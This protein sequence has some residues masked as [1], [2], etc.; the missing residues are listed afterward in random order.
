MKKFFVFMIIVLSFSIL[1]AELSDTIWTHP[2]WGI[3]KAVKFSPDGKYIYAGSDK[4]WIT[5]IDA[6]TNKEIYGINTPADF[7]SMDLSKDGKYILLTASKDTV[8]LINAEDKA[9]IRQFIIP[10]GTELKGLPQNASI[11][12]DSKYCSITYHRSLPNFKSKISILVWELETGKL[13]KDIDASNPGADFLK[14]SPRENIF[15]VGNYKGDNGKATIDIYSTETWDILYTLGGHTVNLEG[16]NFSP[17]GNYL[18][19]WSSADDSNLIKV[20]D[21]KNRKLNQNINGIDYRIAEVW[22]ACFLNN[23]SIIA[24]S[25]TLINL[26]LRF[27]FILINLDKQTKTVIDELKSGYSCDINILNSKSLL[28]CA[29]YGGATLYNLANTLDVPI[30]NQK[31]ITLYPNPATKELNVSL[32][33]I[34]NTPVVYRIINSIGQEILHN[35][36][37][38][39]NNLL[40]INVASLPKGSYILNLQYNN[41]SKSFNFIIQ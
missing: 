29:N 19:S 23:N 13:I 12:Y 28:A 26:K 41:T 37:F 21:I 5:K 18:A 31:P 25:E 8:L 11:S 10:A 2:L 39:Q 36:S 17:D 33:N 1:K 35:S 3:I 30:D 34:N 4:N 38:V 16:I 7:M 20:W 22:D 6:V 24:S 40:R 27:E 32:Q 14:F 15:A 9:L